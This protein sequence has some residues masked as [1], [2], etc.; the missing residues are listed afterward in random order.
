MPRASQ[1][2]RTRVR[3]GLRALG[4]AIQVVAALWIVL[5]I[6]VGFEVAGE[7]DLAS[8]VGV[9]AVAGIGVLGVWLARRLTRWASDTLQQT[10]RADVQA[11]PNWDGTPYGI[12]E[13]DGRFQV[14][15]SVTAVVAGCVL[16]LGFAAAGVASLPDEYG[17]RSLISFSGFALLS[18]LF[19]VI[20]AG[21]R[22]VIDTDGIEVR[23]PWPRCW[24][25]DDVPIIRSVRVRRGSDYVQLTG[26][27]GRR[28]RL[29]LPVAVLEVSAVDLV[30]FIRSQRGF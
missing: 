1:M 13:R 10:M 25:W 16:T 9:I 7:W 11:L 18:L 2:P 30:R 5:F 15:T 20:F 3:R 23:R 4:I 26:P 17:M 29:I 24:A 21:V 8:I 27:G 19:V 12:E 28:P 6:V 14:R 22:Y